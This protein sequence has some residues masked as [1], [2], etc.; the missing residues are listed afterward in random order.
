MAK[1]IKSKRND[2]STHI[3]NKKTKECIALVWSSEGKQIKAK[4][5]YFIISDFGKRW[6]VTRQLLQLIVTKGIAKT[7]MVKTYLDKLEVFKWLEPDEIHPWVPA[8]YPEI[9]C[10]SGGYGQEERGQGSAWAENQSEWAEG[11]SLWQT[12]VWASGLA[13]V[14]S[15]CIHWHHE[16]F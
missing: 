13:Q 7:E 15:G 9:F 8:T 2:F 14:A 4:I 16:H 10:I 12:A 5:Q 3:R 1:N 11:L 6:T